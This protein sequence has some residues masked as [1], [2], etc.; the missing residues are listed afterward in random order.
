MLTEICNYLRN[1]FCDERHIGY[2]RISDG[3][4]YCN[5]AKLNIADGQYFRIVGSLLSDGVYKYGVDQLGD[6]G[7]QGA[8]WLMRVPSDVIALSEEIAAWVEK[9][10]NLDSEAMSPYSSES[11]GG[12]SYSKSVG[13]SEDGSSDASSWQSV[14]KARLAR[15]RRL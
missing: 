8:V 7:F 10:G 15:Y 9:Y 3:D 6:E 11:F 13:V 12:Y 1:W 14:F 4:I 2:V 5:D